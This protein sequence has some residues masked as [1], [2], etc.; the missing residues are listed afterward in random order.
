MYTPR[1]F[2]EERPEVL[3]AAIER[4]NLATLVTV[5]AKI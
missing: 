2:R 4:I 5:G 3:R 1:I